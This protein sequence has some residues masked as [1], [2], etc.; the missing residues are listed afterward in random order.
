MTY[1]Q[2]SLIL[3]FVIPI[4]SWYAAVWM[5]DYFDGKK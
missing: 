1:L 2:F 5:T 3:L 4:A